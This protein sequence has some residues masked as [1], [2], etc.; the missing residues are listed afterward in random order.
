MAESISQQVKKLMGENPDISNKE[1]YERFPNVT[2]TTL[3]YYKSKYSRGKD[4][5]NS[6]G[7]SSKAK[8]SKTSAGSAAAMK[9]EKELLKKRVFAY[10]NKSPEK[11]NED[12]YQA[13]PKVSKY[14]LRGLKTSHRKRREAENGTGPVP[15]K[16]RRTVRRKAATQKAQSRR[17][18]KRTSQRKEAVRKMGDVKS[19]VAA[20]AKRLG[21]G[22]FS[23]VKA[24]GK[25]LNEFRRTVTREIS[26]IVEN[27]KS[28][29]R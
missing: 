21:G 19:S 20:G 7:R 28:R 3:R 24:G 27:R 16:K 6:A 10:L 5:E 9:R 4:A 26:S 18:Q 15:G 2:Q 13:F 23:F 11:S 1:M 12:L 17:G 29:K 14:A 22:L 8:R 25:G